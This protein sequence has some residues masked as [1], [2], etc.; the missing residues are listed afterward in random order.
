[1]KLKYKRLSFETGRVETQCCSKLL[2]KQNNLR[3]EIVLNPNVVAETDLI[4]E[5]DCPN[6]GRPNFIKPL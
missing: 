3:C 2:F 4:I 6:C 5:V 1:M